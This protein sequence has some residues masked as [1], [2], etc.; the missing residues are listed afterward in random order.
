[1]PIRVS[2]RARP[3]RILWIGLSLGLAGCANAPVPAVADYRCDG[4][5]EFSVSYAP[6]RQTALIDIGGMRFALEAQPAAAGA[7]ERY[8]CSV[9]ALSRDGDRARVEMQGSGLYTNCRL[10]R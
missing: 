6:S 5:R 8:A 10:A 9:L 2:H 3:P 1:M 7:G 4:G